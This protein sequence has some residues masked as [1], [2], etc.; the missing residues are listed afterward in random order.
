M[1]LSFHHASSAKA[2]IWQM[3]SGYVLHLDIARDCDGAVMRISIFGELANLQAICASAGS[4]AVVDL[5]NSAA[6]GGAS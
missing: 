6:V 2:E 3:D 1:N 5:R 4:V